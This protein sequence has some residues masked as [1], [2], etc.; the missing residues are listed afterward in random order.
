MSLTNEILA[1]VRNGVALDGEYLDKSY[2]GFAYVRGDGLTDYRPKNDKLFSVYMV[3]GYITQNVC[4]DN[5]T[6]I[7]KYSKVVVARYDRTD[8]GSNPLYKLLFTFAEYDTHL[9]PKLV[10]FASLLICKLLTHKW[11]I[12]WILVCLILLLKVLV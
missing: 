9:S 10:P 6:I 12:I 5:N 1:S 7:P 4:V 8:G 2:T 11:N 3:G